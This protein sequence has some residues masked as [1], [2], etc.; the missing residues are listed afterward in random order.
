MRL[1]PP[2]A[3]FGRMNS[4][5]RDL[6]AAF[7]ATR[8]LPRA[9][10]LLIAAFVVDS[11]A[12][13]GNLTLMSEY[14]S[15]DIGWGD[16]HA[17]WGVSL[18]TMSA[19]LFMLGAGSLAEGFGL[20]RAVI[21]ALCL[22]IAGRVAYC[23][24]PGQTFGVATTL[25][26]CAPV[27][28]SLG[29]AVLQ[30]VCYSGVKQLTDPSTASMGYAMIYAMMNAGIVAVGTLSAWIRPAVQ[31]LKDGHG[32]GDPVAGWFASFS[33]TGIQAVNWLCVGITVLTLLG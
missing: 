13:F 9:A 19:T 3:F 5:F 27:V 11:M 28:I 25:V 21:G 10:W 4:P 31:D 32:D 30:P 15:A 16:A 6:A 7:A 14:L 24:A 22:T 18:F 20:R 1:R 8:R 23:L 33:G 2:R 29:E 17:G 26:I 12:Y